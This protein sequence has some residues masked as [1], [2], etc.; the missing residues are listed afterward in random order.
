M[1]YVDFGSELKLLPFV[2]HVEHDANHLFKV[3]SE[4]AEFVSIV[5]INEDGVV[6]SSNDL[7]SIR[8][9][10]N[11]DAFIRAV[12][13]YFQ[14]EQLLSAMRTH[15][16][17]TSITRKGSLFKTG[18]TSIIAQARDGKVSSSIG[19]YAS[20]ATFLTSL[21]VGK[22][23]YME[24]ESRL[25][26]VSFI[27]QVQRDDDYFM[28]QTTYDAIVSFSVQADWYV[29]TSITFE[30]VY[31]FSTVDDLVAAIARTVA[32][33]YLLYEMQNYF[34][35]ADIKRDCDVF[36]IGQLVISARYKDGM[37]EASTGD[38][39]NIKSFLASLVVG[40]KFDDNKPQWDLIPKGTLVQV[41][42]VL[43][44]GAK[45]YSPDNW[46]KVAPT[47]YYNAMM[48]HIDAWR[49]GERID[50]ETECNHLAHAICCALF[51][52]WF[53]GEE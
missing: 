43:T 33:D 17:D 32:Q 12:D 53:D 21:Q 14:Q 36:T 26:A 22:T 40:V 15:L 6:H 9:F 38:Y 5:T 20:I 44:F 28:F 3:C 11:T 48:R 50:P 13:L 1:K 8:Y 19:E 25:E 10:D 52:L 23:P 30:G 47:R 35:D 29:S 51:L 31:C 46:M 39:S 37:V 27:K 24:I 42:N 45:K 2:T 4:V 49:Q 18:G 41:V 7:D 34:P 16:N